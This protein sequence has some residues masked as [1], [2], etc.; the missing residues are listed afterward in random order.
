MML[1]KQN[2]VVGDPQRVADA[3]LHPQLVEEPC[4]HRLAEDG[5]GARHLSERRL[6]DAIE[7]DERLFEER[8][9]VD[10]RSL[11]A[12]LVETEL[13]GARGKPEVVLDAREAFLFRRGDEM[14]V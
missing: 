7:L 8:D 6:Q 4:G 3:V 9:A 14:T 11:D 13:N 10:V 12:G 1:G 2:P 5:P